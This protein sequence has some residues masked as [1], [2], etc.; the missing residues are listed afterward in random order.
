MSST[1]AP[2]LVADHLLNRLQNQRIIQL[3]QEV[4]DPIANKLCAQLLLLA[5]ED[6]RRDCYSAYHCP[7]T[8]VWG[9]VWV[10]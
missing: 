6:P 2:D 3:G 10:W 8:T 7:A 1:E 5:E 4:D 9:C